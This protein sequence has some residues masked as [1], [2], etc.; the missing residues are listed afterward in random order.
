MN[1]M[2]TD[3]QN[4]LKKIRKMIIKG[5]PTRDIIEQVSSEY[6]LSNKTVENYLVEVRKD[7][8][9][10][11]LKDKETFLEDFSNKYL[12]LYEQLVE[13]GQYLAAKNVLDS[14]VKLTGLLNT[15]MT[16]S[17]NENSKINIS[18]G[19]SKNEETE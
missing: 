5:K 15:D 16:V 2:N 7:V 12:Y 10:Y 17:L 19:L 18:F 11:Y 13:A 14:H 8:K 9:Y 6:E 4:I 1:D 3:K